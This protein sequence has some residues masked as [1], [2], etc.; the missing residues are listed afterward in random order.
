MQFMLKKKK[1]WQ[2]D[3]I[4]KRIY[5][6]VVPNLLLVDYIKNLI[7]YFSNKNAS[8]IFGGHYIMMNDRH[9]VIN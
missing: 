6:K 8:K 1:T 3:Q 7:T 4:F 2:D 5:Y 9:Y